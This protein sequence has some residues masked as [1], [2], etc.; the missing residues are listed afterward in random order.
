MQAFFD[1]DHT[2]VDANSDTAVF[3]DLDPELHRAL[4]P[5]RAPRVRASGVSYVVRSPRSQNNP[6]TTDASPASSR[7]EATSP[8]RLLA[9]SARGLGRGGARGRMDRGHGPGAG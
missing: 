8:L 1:F 3:R 9:R 5:V 2:L 4:R 6:N 7:R